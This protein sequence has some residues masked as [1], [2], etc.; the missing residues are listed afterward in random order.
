MIKR[1]I[2]A[3]FLWASPETY[4][5]EENRLDLSTISL[6]QIGQTVPEIFEAKQGKG[7]LEPTGKIFNYHGHRFQIRNFYFEDKR[8]QKDFSQSFKDYLKSSG[9]EEFLPRIVNQGYGPLLMYLIPDPNFFCFLCVRPEPVH[10]YDEAKYPMIKQPITANYIVPG[11]NYRLQELLDKLPEFAQSSSSW[12]ISSC[13]G[14]EITLSTGKKYQISQAFF[15]DP[16]KKLPAGQTVAEFVSLQKI[17]YH[18]TIGVNYHGM[19][20][21]VFYRPAFDYDDHIVLYFNLKLL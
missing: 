13:V 18:T 3:A 11:D 10:G 15:E 12:M 16:L 5:A 14:Q 7:T 9:R 19:F 20:S 6:T 21:E 17:T 1:F 2:L 8:D 4:A